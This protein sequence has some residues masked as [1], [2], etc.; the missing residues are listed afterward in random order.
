M[1]HVIERAAT[2]RAKCRACGAAVAKGE[3]RIGEVVPNLYADAEGAE[4]LHWYHPWC[5]AYQRP[6]AALQALGAAADGPSDRA[7]LIAAAEHGVAHPRVVRVHAAGRAPTGRAACRHCRA[8]IAKGAWR[9]AL[10]FWQDGRFAPAGFIHAACAGP[11]LETTAIGDRL[12]YFTP[13]LSDDDAAALTAELDR[14][15]PATAEADAD[16][17]A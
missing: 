8:P 2:G 3:W 10:L 17:N 12:R 14:P 6:E 15:P 9:I 13:G 5:A 11:Y 1:P 4:V 7:A 16:A